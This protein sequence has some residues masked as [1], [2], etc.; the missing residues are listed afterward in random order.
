MHNW[1]SRNRLGQFSLMGESAQDAR[2]SLKVP[3]FH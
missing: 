1:L 2:L 3:A